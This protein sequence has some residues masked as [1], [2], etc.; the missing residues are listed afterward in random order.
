MKLELDVQVATEAP[1]LP[2]HADFER[3]VKGA[4]AHTDMQDA[5]LTIRL[6][7]EAESQQ[8]NNEFRQKN[9]PTNVLSFPYEGFDLGDISFPDQQPQTLELPLLGDLVIC[10]PVVARE[11]QE[12]DKALHH[13]WAHL[14]VHGVLHLLGYDHITDT[15]AE[16][17]EDLERLILSTFD[18]ADPYQ[19]DDTE[20]SNRSV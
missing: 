12:Q 8:L 14:V 18:I 17:M 13:H 2:Q 20:E 5:E 6:V 9:K 3:W 15:E 4:M 1:A 19:S 11:A 16:E 10:A 7:D